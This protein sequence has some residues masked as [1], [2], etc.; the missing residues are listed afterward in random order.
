MKLRFKNYIPIILIILLAIF[1]RFVNIN[2]NPPSMYGDELTLV[3]DAYSILK[4]GHDQ[5]GAFLP[6]T[7][8]MS[9]GR[10]PAYVYLTVP[11]VAAFGPTAFAAR[12]FSLVSGVGI[13]LLLYLILKSLV[14]ERVATIG[15]LFA[16]ISPWDLSLSRGGFETHLA[17]FLSLLGVYAAVRAKV[18][19]WYLLI[20]G[21]SFGLAIFTYHSYKVVVPA[22]LPFLL[23]FID[24]KQLIKDK[25]FRKS[26]I[27]GATAFLFFVSFWL[28]Q[29]IGGSE[30]RFQNTS[31]LSNAKLSSTITEKVNTE[32]TLD[33]SPFKVIIHNRPV[34]YLTTLGDN[35]FSHFSFDFLFLHGDGNPRHNQ[36]LMGEMYI[37]DSLLVLL[38]II[39]LWQKYKKVALLLGGWM[40]VSPLATMVVS[41]AH[42]LRSTFLLPPLLILSATGFTYLLELSRDKWV[43]KLVF[44][45]VVLGIITQFIFLVDR[46]YYLYPKQFG[47]FWSLSAKTASEDALAES[48]KYDYV[49]LSDQIDSINLAFPVYV[50]VDPNQVI[51]QYNQNVR[52]FG[53]IYIGKVSNLPG[54]VLYIKNNQ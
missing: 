33:N 46:V 2:S 22:F 16:A 41:P 34:E 9:E 10:P 35:Y 12:F 14:S 19:P 11:L 40:I 47:S 13:V 48:K 21:I 44:F 24:L 31:L 3:Y 51:S 36:G 25:K 43:A 28:Y 23:W 15:A 49:V 53:N 30:I 1:L 45:A 42:A 37:A 7:F 8:A 20:S 39:F 52:N 17:L 38:G 4:T 32:R 26:F 5:T 54:N 29:V 6:L 18:R 50:K 27:I